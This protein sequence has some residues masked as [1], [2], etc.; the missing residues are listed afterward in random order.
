[1]NFFK[2]LRYFVVGFV[3]GTVVA[4][5]MIMSGDLLRRPAERQLIDDWR[6]IQ[7]GMLVTEVQSLL[8]E[9]SGRFPRGD[10]LPLWA[11]Q[12]V[13]KDFSQSHGLVTYVIGGIGPQVLLIYFDEQ[14]RV[15]FVSSTTT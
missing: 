7:P 1:M 2:S 15:V 8:G 14:N 10:S 12:S 3:I 5:F 4:S 9:S 11:E 6:K 13:P